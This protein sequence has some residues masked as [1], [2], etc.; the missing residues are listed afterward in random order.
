MPETETLTLMY[1][2]KIFL[3]VGISFFIVTMIGLMD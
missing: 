3:I 2:I 1:L